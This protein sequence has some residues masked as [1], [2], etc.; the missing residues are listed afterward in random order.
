M[1]NQLMAGTELRWIIHVNQV[2]AG[3]VCW[4]VD[5]SVCVISWLVLGEVTVEMR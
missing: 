4:S 1:N 3:I 5:M 2:I